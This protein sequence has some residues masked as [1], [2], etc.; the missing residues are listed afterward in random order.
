MNRDGKPDL[1]VTD[2]DY[3]VSVVVG[4]GVVGRYWIQSDLNKLMA[5][6]AGR[7]RRVLVG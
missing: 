4:A 3:E 1:V 2:T 5:G 6:L 7:Q